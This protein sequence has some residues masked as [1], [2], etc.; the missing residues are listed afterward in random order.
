MLR[1]IG[2]CVLVALA[3]VGLNTILEDQKEL[4]SRAAGYKND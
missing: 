4:R 3:S 2:F 1:L